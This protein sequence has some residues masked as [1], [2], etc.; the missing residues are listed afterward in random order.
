MSNR[1]YTVLIIPEKTSQMRRIILPS[2]VVRFSALILA[3]C[4]LLATVM[5]F[6]YWYVMNQIGENKQL[7]LENRRLRQQVQIFQ[8]KVSTVENTMDRIKN[9]ATRLKVIMHLEDQ[10]PQ[11]QV[12]LTPNSLAAPNSG[13]TPFDLAETPLITEGVSGPSDDKT[14][15]SD[16]RD[17][18][19]I[20]LRKEYAALD[21]K[22]SALNRDAFVT[23]ELLQDEYEILYDKKAFLAA[24]PTRQ[25]SL[26]LFH[27][28]FW[29][30][31][32]SLR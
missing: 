32:L 27:F 16:F 23:E 1:S 30:A 15:V 7:K 18:E 20:E 31:G 6:D 17:P 25:T 28:R 22:L 3:F 13:T 4:F 2:W 5:I 9:F 24:L 8:N 11:L 26:R 14:S 19:K 29:G 21:Q 12:S 10:G